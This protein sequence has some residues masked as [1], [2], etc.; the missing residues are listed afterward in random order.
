MKFYGLVSFFTAIHTLY[1]LTIG[2]CI[3]LKL[4]VS[5]INGV[6]NTQVELKDTGD[7]KI[8]QFRNICSENLHTQIFEEN[9]YKLTIYHKEK[10]WK[11]NIPEHMPGKRNLNLIETYCISNK[12]NC[13]W[14]YEDNYCIL[15]Y[16]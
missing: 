13:C 10:E 5:S 14:R 7:V 4:N 12:E 15:N 2:T 16:Q 1:S 9:G 11:L 6:V 8:S 3:D